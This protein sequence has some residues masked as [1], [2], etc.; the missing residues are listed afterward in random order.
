MIKIIT[1]RT[2]HEYTIEVFNFADTWRLPEPAPQ[3]WNELV[4]QV[5]KNG[6]KLKKFPITV[7]K[8]GTQ[9][10]RDMNKFRT[11]SGENAMIEIAKWLRGES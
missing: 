2:Y 11:A 4:Y 10:V 5:T 9:L 6:K 3:D 7:A 8:I 1:S